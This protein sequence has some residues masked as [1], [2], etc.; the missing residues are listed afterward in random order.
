MASWL[1]SLLLGLSLLPGAAGLA[2]VDPGSAA[3]GSSVAAGVRPAEEGGTC[4]TTEMLHGSDAAGE[5][6]A[7]LAVRDF[8]R[9]QPQRAAA[10]AWREVNR[11]SGA[12]TFGFGKGRVRVLALPAGGWAVDS[13]TW[14]S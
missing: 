12:V 2:G 11:G 8:L 14:C 5:R 6:T 4:T 3:V 1:V 13:A 7:Q 9:G 10:S